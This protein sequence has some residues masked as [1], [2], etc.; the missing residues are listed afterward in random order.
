M[1]SIF[2]LRDTHFS[3]AFISIM[4]IHLTGC[5]GGGGAES[6]A[7]S[8]NSTNSASTHS[9]QDNT[10]QSTSSPNTTLP[11]GS[12]YSLV[13]SQGNVIETG[14][15]N[16]ER[17]SYSNGSTGSGSKP[18]AEQADMSP[19]VE[20]INATSDT[21]P[22]VLENDDRFPVYAQAYPYRATARITYNG[23]SY[24]TGWLVSKDTLVT[25][26]HCIHGGGPNN[27]WLTQGKLRVYPG[28]ADGYAPFG[29][30]GVRETYA[31]YAW[32]TQ[33]S[34]DADVGII[35]LNCSIGNSTGYFSY[36]VTTP[37]STDLLTIS[38]Y[39][40]DKAGGNE[41]WASHGNLLFATPGKLYYDNDTYSG[42]SGSPV[43][44]ENG[45]AI[46]EAVALHTNTASTNTGDANAGTR[47][48]QAVFD[49]I[50]AASKIP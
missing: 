15:F 41:Q 44:L 48:S 50:Q 46:A 10:A 37:N 20:T 23:N 29:S 12:A 22:R 36:A 47:I 33:A 17:S 7:S 25:A 1:G 38:G 24:C 39:P 2:R 35:K 3:I 18:V 9:T 5:G 26:G 31:S 30:C 32:V 21:A 40:A 42:M 19:Q 43:W 14:S 16:P 27:S 4:L 34:S 13:S 28:F 8:S 11:T 49:L 6:Q 45:A